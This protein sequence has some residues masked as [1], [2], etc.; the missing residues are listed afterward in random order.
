M[1]H[2]RIVE[3]GWTVAERDLNRCELHTGVEHMLF[4]A[5]IECHPASPTDGVRHNGDDVKEIRAHENLPLVQ[6][7][8]VNSFDAGQPERSGSAI[9]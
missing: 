6:S 1:V 8:K 5:L 9:G 7:F 3:F 2:M 4:E